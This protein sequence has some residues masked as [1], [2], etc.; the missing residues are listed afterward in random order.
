MDHIW[1]IMLI[2]YSGSLLFINIIFMATCLQAVPEAQ[3][4]DKNRMNISPRRNVINLC[5]KHVFAVTDLGWMNYDN[6]QTRTT[7]HHHRSI[8]LVNT[9]ETIPLGLQPPD[10]T[11]RI[12][13]PTGLYHRSIT[14]FHPY[15]SE[16]LIHFMVIGNSRLG[17]LKLDSSLLCCEC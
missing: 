1:S 14:T 17:I 6:T 13:P 16:E 15:L 3:T 9:T 12:P 4:A 2:L 5:Q 8:S 10:N 11:Q 7:N